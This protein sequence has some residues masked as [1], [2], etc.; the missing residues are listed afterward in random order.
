MVCITVLIVVPNSFFAR[1]IKLFSSSR[2]ANRAA[3]P[4]TIIHIGLEE[5]NQCQDRNSIP[6]IQ[7]SNGTNPLGWTTTGLSGGDQGVGNAEDECIVHYTKV[8]SCGTRHLSNDAANNVWVSGTGCGRPW[9]LVKGGRFDTNQSGT[10]IRSR[11]GFGY[12][13]YGG[14]IDPSVISSSLEPGPSS[15]CRIKHIRS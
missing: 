5:N 3:N 14:L 11:S 4:G 6:G 15:W 10:I 1:S 12:G 7:T 9:D 8:S 13:G 2:V